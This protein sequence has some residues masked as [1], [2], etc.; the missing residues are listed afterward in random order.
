MGT[1][2]AQDF[3]IFGAEW[4]LPRTAGHNLFHGIILR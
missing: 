1:G 4:Q 2:T 3:E